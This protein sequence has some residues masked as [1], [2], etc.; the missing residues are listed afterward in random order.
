MKFRAYSLLLIIG[1]CLLQQSAALVITPTEISDLEILSRQNGEQGGILSLI[2]HTITAAGYTSLA[3]V[4]THP[5]ESSAMLKERQRLIQALQDPEKKNK[6]TKQLMIIKQYEPLLKSCFDATTREQLTTVLKKNYYQWGRLQ[7]LNDSAIALE[8]LHLFEF[9]SLFGPLI[10]HLILHFA[11][12]FIQEKINTPQAPTPHVHTAACN[13]NHTPHHHNNFRFSQ[14]NKHS[15][16]EAMSHVCLDCHLQTHPENA[17]WKNYLISTI[18]A[19]H[20]VFHLFNIK[21]MIDHLIYKAEI[22]NLIHQQVIATYA[23]IQACAIIG[24]E[25][26]HLALQDTGLNTQLLTELCDTHTDLVLQSFDRTFQATPKNKLGMFSSV[27]STLAAYQR[28]SNEKDLIA[29]LMQATG[30]IDAMLSVGTLLT[31]HANRYCIATYQDGVE[32]YFSLEA[33]THPQIEDG[34]AVSNDI[35]FSSENG[36]TKVVITGPNTAGKS[37]IAKGIALNALL[38]QTIGIGCGKALTMTPF[39]KIVTYMSVHDDITNHASTFMTELKRAENLINDLERIDRKAPTLVILDDALFRST[40]ADKSEAAAYALVER[41][42][43]L[44]KGIVLTITHYDKVP[45]L[46]SETQG[47]IKNFRIGVKHNPMTGLNESSYQLERGISPK[48][49]IFSLVFN[50]F[51]SS[52]FSIA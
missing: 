26:N 15:G 11:L 25:I 10:E 31:N 36:L 49:E 1:F 6:I 44:K 34:I 8:I 52:L 38:G 23:C 13:H 27:G 42:S 29:Q 30:N 33:F 45:L 43:H 50:D 41:L 16:H 39:K 14:R 22:I 47:L 9:A 4:L 32:P 17:A 28:L 40:Q 12:E 51:R 18:K 24:D 20:F 3:T 2:D 35:T 46:E 37:C 19:G 7:G 21:E 48:E 5:I